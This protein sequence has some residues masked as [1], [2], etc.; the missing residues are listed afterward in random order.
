MELITALSSLSLGSVVPMLLMLNVYVIAPS[1]NAPTPDSRFLY[2]AVY[3]LCTVLA[4]NYARARN[5]IDTELPPYSAEAAREFRA[6][7]AATR[8]EGLNP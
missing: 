4:G 1:L 2:R 5:A 7:D 6:H 8:N 3:R